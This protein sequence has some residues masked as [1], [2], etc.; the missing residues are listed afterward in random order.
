MEGAGVKRGQNRATKIIALILVLAMAGG[1]LATGL[2]MLLAGRPD[3]QG[4]YRASDGREMVLKGG[5]ATITVPD[6]GS[7][8]A[9]YR[10]RGDSV[11]IRVDERNEISFDIDGSD[12]V[13]RHDGTTDRWVRQ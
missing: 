2:V 7:A 6:Q 12:L 9:T 8:T 5:S 1:G 3:V 11:V 13:M 10:V 4:T